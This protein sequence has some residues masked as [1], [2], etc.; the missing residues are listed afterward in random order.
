LIFP[1][2]FPPKKQLPNLQPSL[3]NS[4]PIEKNNQQPTTMTFSKMFIQ[5]ER[6]WIVYDVIIRDSSFLIREEHFPKI[7]DIFS[8]IYKCKMDEDDSVG[9]KL[10]KLFAMTGYE[11]EFEG[12]ELCVPCEGHIEDIK[13]LM[14]ENITH[15]PLAKVLK[16]IAQYVEHDSFF[17][18]KVARPDFDM[19]GRNMYYERHRLYFDGDNLEDQQASITWS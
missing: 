8:K 12:D 19:G 16:P 18:Y 14:K 10:K 13:A 3:F 6:S 5:G 9:S 2:P 4:N 17:E 7:L 15:L 1:R 11:I